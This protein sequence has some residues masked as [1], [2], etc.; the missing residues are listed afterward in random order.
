MTPTEQ[1]RKAVGYALEEAEMTLDEA[2]SFR[3]SGADSLAGIR[4]RETA[5]AEVGK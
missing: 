5:D 1:A 3:P 4:G 2:R